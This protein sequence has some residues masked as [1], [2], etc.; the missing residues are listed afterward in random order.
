MD[1]KTSEAFI[2]K[3]NE[4]KRQ[5]SSALIHLQISSPQN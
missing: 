1:G 2:F 5:F 3:I 4:L